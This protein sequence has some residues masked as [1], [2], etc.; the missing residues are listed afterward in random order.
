MAVVAIALI[1]LWLVLEPSGSRETAPEFVLY[2]SQPGPAVEGSP[3]TGNWAAPAGVVAIGT[4]LFVLDSGNDRVL[5]LD[6][7]GRVTGVLC[8]SGDCQFLLKNPQALATDGEKLYVANTVA[9]Q[10]VVLS[11]DG[12]IVS[13][14]KIVPPGSPN[15]GE[16]TP[17]GIAVSPTGEVYVSDRARDLVLRLSS[18]SRSTSVFLDGLGESEKYRAVKPMG[19]AVDVWGNIY[20]ANSGSGPIRKYSAAGRHLQEF[21]LRSN[22][23]FFS[24]AYVA[25]DGRGNVYFTDNRSRLVYV[26]TEAGDL[27]GVVGLLDSGRVDSPGVLREPWGLNMVRGTLYIA[28]KESGLFG[29]RIDPDYWKSA[30][31]SQ[32][33]RHP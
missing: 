7:A 23:A 24:P 10:V 28:D 33:G 8:E 13:T 2:F 29:F 11:T 30:Q 1:T 6:P 18:D 32:A 4:R 25:L 9:G 12:S 15:K 14:I 27:A 21:S 5:E 20:V 3:P 26:Y 22:P 17:N 31:H 16:F 19:L